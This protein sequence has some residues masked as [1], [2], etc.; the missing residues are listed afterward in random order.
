MQARTGCSCAGPYGISLLGL[1]DSSLP[2]LKKKLLDGPVIV[3]PGFCRLSLISFMSNAEVS[4]QTIYIFMRHPHGVLRT[5]VEGIVSNSSRSANISH[6][7][8]LR[9]CEVSHRAHEIER[10]IGV[11]DLKTVDSAHVEV[12]YSNAGLRPTFFH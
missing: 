1:P 10:Y 4:V 6:Y 11:K 3:K 9:G 7:L 5:V 8:C 2:K 12:I